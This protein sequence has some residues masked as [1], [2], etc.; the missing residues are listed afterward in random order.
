MPGTPDRLAQ[1]VDRRMALAR[2]W[3]D[4][5]AQVRE[6]PGFEDF[7][8]PPRIETLLPAAQ[9]GPVVILNVSRWR[10]D[11]LVVTLDDVAVV[12]LPALTQESV[13][14]QAN[15]YLQAVGGYEHEAAA[16]LQAEQSFVASDQD[17]NALIAFAEA[18]THWA[19]EG[20]RLEAELRACLAW[21]WDSFAEKVL[22]HLGY[23]AVPDG[24][25]WPR[26]W[27]CPTG[28]LTL[29][30]IHAAGYHERA[31]IAVLDRVVSSYT[32][33]LRALVE[34]RG[35]R[36]TTAAPSR[37]LF[38]G[39]E[40]TPGQPRL[41]NVRRER[42]VLE[43]NLPVD[44]CTTLTEDGATRAAVLTHLTEHSWIHLSCHG[45]QNLADP[46]RG[47]VHLYDGVLTVTDF[48][49]RQYDGEFAYLSGCKTAVGGVHLP[50]EAITLAAALHYTGYR[51]VI[52]TLW[53]VNDLHAAQ[54][55]EDVYGTL[56][57]GGVLDPRDAAR[58]L[59]DAVRALRAAY[60]D[61]PS[62]WTPF[63]HT[64]P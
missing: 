59:H 32:P 21:M 37:M 17:D 49:A 52:A 38:V 9:D 25:T 27:W 29:L 44:R 36:G 56:I 6:L 1:D 46:S 22:E 11:A 40:D 58:A 41:P 4:L 19:K 5:V 13:V 50:D 8:R 47:G 16:Y 39:L 3:D 63:A 57:V 31:G 51:H 42:E 61:R 2:E 53:S 24:P 30:P 20:D 33:T 43:A 34:A 62:V 55:A 23:T 12:E 15:R 14:E 54:I 64:G 10:C 45:D 28:V 60:R 18:G 7:L 35:D 48:S 26:V